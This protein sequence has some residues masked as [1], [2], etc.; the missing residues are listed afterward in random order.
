M[1]DY[2]LLRVHTEGRVGFIA[3]N[4]PPVNSIDGAL[5]TELRT[6]FRGWKED[7]NVGA[8]VVTGGIRNA[9]CTGGDLLELFA[10]RMADFGFDTKLSFFHEFQ[11]IYYE[12]ERY[13]KPTVA[14]INGLA[15][16]AGV[17]LAL[18]CDLRISSDLAYYSLPELAHG[19][20]PNLGATQRLHLCIGAT[21]A[22]E[23]MLSGK[24]IRAK[25][26]LEWGLVN[27]VV[28]AKS[29]KARVTELAGELSKLPAPAVA[30]L[31][32]CMSSAYASG[33]TR[34]GLRKETETFTTL[35][36]DKLN[37]GGVRQPEN[38]T[39]G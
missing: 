13:P 9:F 11:E 29:L 25:T 15:I 35:L 18:V 16:G 23:M 6:A 26:A 4:R 33:L 20:I 17:E 28:P 12:I 21:H 22:K 8:I 19:I 31:K 14:A 30:A 24:R 36:H 2:K 3:L 5:L 37:D 10:Q 34:E 39:K 32:T 38:K 7:D 1:P 27:E